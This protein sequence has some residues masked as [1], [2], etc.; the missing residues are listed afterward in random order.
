[1]QTEKIFVNNPHIKELEKRIEDLKLQMPK[2]SIP[3]AMIIELEDLEDELEDAQK[4]INSV[5]DS[6]A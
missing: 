4:V 1:M 3:P 5:D 6:D 2:H